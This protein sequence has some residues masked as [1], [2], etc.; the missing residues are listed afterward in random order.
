MERSQRA[1]VWEDCLQLA[2]VAICMA[3]LATCSRAAVAY[4][5]RSHYWGQSL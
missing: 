5:L 4:M 3:G 1:T 2:L